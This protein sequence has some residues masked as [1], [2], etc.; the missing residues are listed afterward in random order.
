MTCSQLIVQRDN[1]FVVT[2]GEGSGRL[3]EIVR[4]CGRLRANVAGSQVYERSAIALW[5]YAANGGSA[6]DL[7]RR[8]AESASEALPTSL[9]AWIEQTVARYGVLRLA[10]VTALSGSQLRLMSRFGCSG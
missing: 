2:A 4:Q 7:V 6:S 8:L 10:E 3:A 5:G 9:V 1:Q